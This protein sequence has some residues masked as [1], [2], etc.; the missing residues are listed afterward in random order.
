MKRGRRSGRLQYKQNSSIIPLY[1][2]KC[3]VGR[4]PPSFQNIQWKSFCTYTICCMDWA[5]QFTQMGSSILNVEISHVEQNNIVWFQLTSLSSR[6][7]L[8]LWKYTCFVNALFIYCHSIARNYSYRPLK[9]TGSQDILGC[10]GIKWEDV[11]LKWSSRQKGYQ[12]KLLN[13]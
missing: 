4:G 2:L 10:P 7:S 12:D 11:I 8:Q 6:W 5:F 3:D 13:C 1:A 9:K